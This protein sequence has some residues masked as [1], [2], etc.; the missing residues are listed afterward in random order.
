M[1][2]GPFILLDS[3]RCRQNIARMEEKARTN[4]LVF[5]PHFKTHQSHAVGR[6]FREVG[7]NRITVSSAEMAGYF[8]KDG[9]N[10]ITIAFPLSR[11]HVEAVNRLAEDIHMNIT[12]SSIR[13]LLDALP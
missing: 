3:A 11:F 8:A 12:F 13:N 7:V 2:S 10:D 4:G 6:W 1:S 9:W 5:R